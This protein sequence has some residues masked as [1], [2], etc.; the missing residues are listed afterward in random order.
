MLNATASCALLAQPTLPPAT[1][2][3]EPKSAQGRPE[4]AAVRACVIELKTGERVEG[5]FRQVTDD[6]AVVEVAGQRISIPLAKVNAVYFGTPGTR[7]TASVKLFQ[8]ALDAL[9]EMRSLFQPGTGLG[10]NAF[11]ARLLDIRVKVDKYAASPGANADA[12]RLIRVAMLDYDLIRLGMNSEKTA[13]LP[14]IGELL[15]DSDVAKCDGLNALTDDTL[16]K[17]QQALKGI[18][19]DT[20]QVNYKILRQAHVFD[21]KDNLA[22]NFLAKAPFTSVAACAAEQ[23]SRAERFSQ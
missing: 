12:R 8:E 13:F 21:E 16:S 6:G 20:A 18:Y 15:S 5:V 22:L 10:Y 1:R 11:A 7:T 23:I 2:T 9:K 3:A 14:N 17:D 19:R 4:S